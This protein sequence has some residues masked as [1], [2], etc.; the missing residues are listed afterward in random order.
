M[1]YSFLKSGVIPDQLPPSSSSIPR[2]IWQTC[3]DKN[4]IKPDLLNCISQ[5]KEMN[6]N[7]K[8]TLFDDVSQY[9]FIKSVGS[10]RFI[11]SYERIHPLFGAA[12]ADLF[13]YLIVFLHGGAY[14]D[15]KS[16][17]IR[18]LDDIL[19]KTIHLSSRNGTTVLT[20]GSP[21]VEL[22]RHLR[23]FPV[24]NMSNGI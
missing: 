7:W 12:R 4:S 2:K 16:G 23:T 15:I 21:E 1:S 22:N 5:L 9:Q 19:K 13:R 20:A 6:P 17:V 11:K 14:F 3:K 18:P 10:N 8:Y 24:A